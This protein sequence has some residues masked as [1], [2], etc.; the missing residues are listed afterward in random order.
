MDMTITYR[1]DGYKVAILETSKK[2]RPVDLKYLGK[3]ECFPCP[4]FVP[5]YKEKGECFTWGYVGERDIMNGYE[6][7][8]KYEREI[9]EKGIL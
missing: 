4:A 1:P 2:Q 5:V 9:M 3:C 6:K 7:Q 8:L